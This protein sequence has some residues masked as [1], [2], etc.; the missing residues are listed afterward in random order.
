MTFC[1]GLL[2]VLAFEVQKLLITKV[3]SLPSVSKNIFE[4]SKARD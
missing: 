2:I 3:L 4:T 1:P